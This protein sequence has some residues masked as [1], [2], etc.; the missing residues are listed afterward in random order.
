V[1]THAVTSDAD[2]AGVELRESSKDGLWQLLGDVAVHVVAVVV[3]GFG[4]IDVEAG[5]GA[6]VVRVVLTL[7]VQTTW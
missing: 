1:S 6:E 5:T 7:D 2:F 3:W 4:G